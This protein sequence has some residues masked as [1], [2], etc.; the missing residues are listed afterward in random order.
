MFALPSPGHD[1]DRDVQVLR[2]NSWKNERN[3]ALDF[4]S[5]ANICFLQFL[6]AAPRRS[7][8]NINDLLQVAKSK[9]KS[10]MRVIAQTKV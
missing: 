8:A 10:T 6:F 2:K 5:S 4:D 1:K 7:L 9:S 3:E